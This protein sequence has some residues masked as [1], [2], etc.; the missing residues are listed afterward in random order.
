M[1]EEKSFQVL[2]PTATPSVATAGMADRPNSL[3]GMRIGLLRNDKLNSE[4]LLDAIYDVLSERF[5]FLIFYLIFLM[6][7]MLHSWQ[8]GTEEAVRRPVC[9]THSS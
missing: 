1:A 6:K 3:A 9:T 8:M 2:D 5:E 7:L 4:S